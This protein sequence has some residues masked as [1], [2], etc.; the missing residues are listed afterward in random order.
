MAK[1]YARLI[2]EG[3]MRLDDVPQLWRDAVEKLIEGA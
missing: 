3:K 1:I 2:L